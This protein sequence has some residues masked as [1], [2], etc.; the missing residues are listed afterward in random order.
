MPFLKNV[1]PIL[2]GNRMTKEILFRQEGSIGVITLNRPQALNALNL[3]MI[4]ML[5]KQLLHW[6]KDDTIRAFLIQGT[7]KAFC[8]G[9]DVRGLY[10]LGM[11]KDIDRKPEQLQ[12][13]WHEYRLNNFIHCLSKPY[14]A[15]MNGITMG[16]GVGISLH[17]SHAIATEQFSFAMPETGIGFFPD[18]GAS[19]LLSRL[20][21]AIGI[22][23]GL[24]G[25]RLSAEEA[26]ELKV[27]K[28][29]ISSENL[30]GIL[31]TLNHLAL[32]REPTEAHNQVTAYFKEISYSKKTNDLKG[33]Q[34]KINE[35]FSKSSVEEIIQAL[36]KSEG[37]WEQNVLNTL[38]QKAPLSLKVTLE[39]LQRAKSMSLSNCLAMDYCLVKQFMKDP[40]FYEGIRAL[41]IDKDKS[42]H[43]LPATLKEVSK[44]QVISFFEF[45]KEILNLEWDEF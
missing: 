14:I 17:G 37:Q 25:A 34:E 13:F 30:D 7:G 1:Q 19:Y 4:I 2:Q 38:Q 44:H 33:Q 41:L 15:L 16:G 39:Q 11:D 5:Q 9:G 43:W 10:H 21:G 18:I 3:E 32:S 22:Y 42:P 26:Y 20:P 6:E 23:L 40:N 27:I 45:E 12:F 31:Q 29:L 8:A 36:E 28:Y 35:Y 24:T